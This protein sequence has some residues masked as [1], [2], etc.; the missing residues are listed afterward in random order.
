MRG[1]Q[2]RNRGEEEKQ[3]WCHSPSLTETDAE[4]EEEELT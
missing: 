1:E 2:T 4:E 3:T